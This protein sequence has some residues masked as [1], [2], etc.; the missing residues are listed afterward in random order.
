MADFGLLGD[1][2]VIDLRPM[3]EGKGVRVFDN[4]SWIP[5]EGTLG[6][7]TDSKPLTAEEAAALTSSETPSQ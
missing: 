6:K 4:D 7:V 5:F 1:G 2:R 3:D